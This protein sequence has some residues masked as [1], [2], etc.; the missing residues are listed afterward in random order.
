MTL[1]NKS[2]TLTNEELEK[3]LDDAFKA[4]AKRIV[5]EPRNHG[6]QKDWGDDGC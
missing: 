5:E 2:A 3:I 6:D 1:V 4:V